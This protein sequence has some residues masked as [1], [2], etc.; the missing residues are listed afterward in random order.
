[1][2]IPDQCCGAAGHRCSALWTGAGVLPEAP[3]VR[4]GNRAADWNFVLA[5][6]CDR[7]AAGF[8]VVELLAVLAK[9]GRSGGCHPAVFVAGDLCSVATGVAVERVERGHGT[10]T[11]VKF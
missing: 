11:V 1:M 5:F 4:A 8:D 10:G 6:A 3:G 2:S 9:N 7:V